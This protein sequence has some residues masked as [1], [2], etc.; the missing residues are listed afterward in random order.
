MV[1]TRSSGV[2][3]KATKASRGSIQNVTA[4]IPMSTKDDEANVPRV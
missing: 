2:T 4:N 3:R 1:V